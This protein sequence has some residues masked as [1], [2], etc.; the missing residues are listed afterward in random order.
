MNHIA[1]LTQDR[2]EARSVI[3]E[4]ECELIALLC[5]LETDKFSGPD[6]DYIHIRTDLLPKLQ[7]ISNTLRGL[8]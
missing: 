5:Y 2:N 3:S 6:N 4:T 1:K 8:D 7:R